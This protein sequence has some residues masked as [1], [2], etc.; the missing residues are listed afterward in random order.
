M[1]PNAGYYLFDFGMNELRMTFHNTSIL[2]EFLMMDQAPPY[3]LIEWL[4]SS[5]I[6]DGITVSP[7]SSPFFRSTQ[8]AGLDEHEMQMDDEMDSLT[9]HSQSCRGWAPVYGIISALREYKLS[10]ERLRQRLSLSHWHT[11]THLFQ[12]PKAV[13]S[14]N[15]GQVREIMESALFAT[16]TS[17]QNTNPPVLFTRRNFILTL[18][19]KYSFDSV[20]QI[21]E[22]KSAQSKLYLLT[23]LYVQVASQWR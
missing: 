13:C 20:S 2:K 14:L 22:S 4:S 17:A 3:K 15:G 1:G 10:A 18:A 7:N 5:Q 6:N 16:G 23:P 19:R 9:I 12:V 8:M 21:Q 11:H